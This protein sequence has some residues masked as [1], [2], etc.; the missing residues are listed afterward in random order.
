MNNTN[1][2]LEARRALLPYPLINQKIRRSQNGIMRLLAISASIFFYAEARSAT[3]YAQSINTAVI[4]SAATASPAERPKEPDPVL[5]KVQILLDRVGI[6]PGVIDG[7]EGENLRKE[8]AAFETL[9]GLP[10]DGMLD[11]Q[12]T[13]WIDLTEPTYGIHGTPEPALIDKAGSH[14]CV[15]LTNRDADKLAGMFESG[16]TV[17]FA[18]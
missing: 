2:T 18:D 13:V 7:L 1:Y 17:E 9:S 11:P 16:V 6:S 15:R 8:I 4:A 12:L 5:L 14:G 3:I 10:D